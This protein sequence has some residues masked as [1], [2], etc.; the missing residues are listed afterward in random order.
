VLAAVNAL[1]TASSRLI[2][3]HARQ[4][5]LPSMGGLLERRPAVIPFALGG[6][7]AGLMAGGFAGTEEVDTY[8]R[9]GLLLWMLHYATVH[10][11]VLHLDTSAGNP[12]DTATAPRNILVPLLGAGLPAVA[13]AVLVITDPERLALL[14]FLACTVGGLFAAGL[15][16]TGKARRGTN[17]SQSIVIYL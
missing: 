17:S 6:V 7:C 15:M 11:A 10:L 16:G 4:G 1:F 9:A 5:L 2:R 3:A 8:L 14:K 13:A 12:S